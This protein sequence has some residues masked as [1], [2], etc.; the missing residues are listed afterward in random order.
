MTGVVKKLAALF[1]LLVGRCPAHHGPLMLDHWP[2]EAKNR[3]DC[4]YCRPFVEDKPRYPYG[5][6]AALGELFRRTKVAP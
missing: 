2:Y 1:W 5:F 3:R 4:F 6:R